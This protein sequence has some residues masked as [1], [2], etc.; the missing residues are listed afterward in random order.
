MKLTCI[1]CSRSARPTPEQADAARHALS[2]SMNELAIGCPDCRRFT[3]HRI[4]AEPE[5]V[6]PSRAPGL[7]YRCPV[8]GCAG[9]LAFVERHGLEG[10][11]H[12]CARCHSVWFSVDSLQTEMAKI[13]ELYPYRAAVYRR[14]DGGYLPVSVTEMPDDYE[15]RVREE[16]DGR[17][18]TH[19]RG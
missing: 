17:T 5:D 1:T 6:R 9:W 3:L 19:V 4:D 18:R 15:S 11:H 7:S 14:T 13:I 2:A 8:A 12:R 16:P 10:A